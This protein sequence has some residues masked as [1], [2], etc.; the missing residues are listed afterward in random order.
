MVAPIDVVGPEGRVDEPHVLYGHVLRVRDIRQPGAL[1][2]LVGA[3]GVPLAP[4]PE[5][6]PVVLSVAVDGSLAADGESVHAIGIDERHKVFAGLPLDARLANLEVVNAV[7]T[8]QHAALFHAQVSAGLEEEAPAI[9]RALWHHDDSPTLVGGTVDDG[10][11]LA[12]LYVGGALAHAIAGE[13]ILPAQAGHIHLRRVGKPS[14]HHLAVGPQWGL[15]GLFLS[16]YRCADHERQQQNHILQSHI[17]A[18]FSGFLGKGTNKRS[19]NQ[20]FHPTKSWKPF[21]FLVLAMHWEG[22]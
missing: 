10:L 14:V 11:Y 16:T 21:I 9:E 8:L 18:T 15:H 22:V 12:R 3:L 13:H 1:G 6:L 20:I 4:N 7:A 17:L 5:L 19:K 2:I